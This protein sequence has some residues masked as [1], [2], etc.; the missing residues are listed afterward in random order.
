MVVGSLFENKGVV[1]MTADEEAA[2]FVKS[3]EDGLTRLE[4]VVQYANYLEA[5]KRG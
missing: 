1:K 2:A 5:K 3:W 4:R